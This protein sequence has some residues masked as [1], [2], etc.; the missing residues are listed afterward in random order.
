MNVLSSLLNF[1][2]VNF[3]TVEVT[4]ST[5]S[6][7]PINITD[8]RITSKHVVVNSVLSNP[9]AQIDNWTVTTSDYVDAN[10]PNIIIT[11]TIGESKTTDITLYFNYKR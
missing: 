3:P 9:S 2:G 8:S 11:G 6:S 10:T 4:K 7:L 1:I 5:I